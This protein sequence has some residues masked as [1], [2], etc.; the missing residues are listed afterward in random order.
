MESGLERNGGTVEESSKRA[1]AETY[2]VASNPITIEYG[3]FNVLFAGN[4][5]TRPKH[6]LGP[7][8]YD[9]YLLHH[10]LS[11]QGTFTCNGETYALRAGHTFLI[12]PEQLISYES[13]AE[14]PWRYSWAA[15]AGEQAPALAASCGLTAAN[16]IAD[17]GGSRQPAIW[18]RRIQRAFTSGSP[19]ASL[20]A[21]GYMHLLLGALASSAAGAGAQPLPASPAAADG[22]AGQ[23]A[24]QIIHYLTTQYAEPVTMERMADAL[25][26]SRA[27]LSRIFKQATGMAPVTFLLKL[28]IDKARQLL[29]D[30]EELTVEQVASSAGFADALYFSKQ[31]R[32]FY[33]L[34]PTGYRESL[35]EQGTRSSD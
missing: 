27:Y 14:E 33:G 34:S 21:A 15:F 2:S 4:S 20:Q 5:Q 25:G 16:P 30:R 12:P 26:Y 18:L 32:R 7:K 9:F 1:L 8:V 23:L 24:Q 31:F 6:R 29:R 10:V 11:G 28:R 22:S 13:D 35:H 19:A 17:T 3:S